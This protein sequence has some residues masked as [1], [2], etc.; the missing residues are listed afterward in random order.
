MSSFLT[1]IFAQ[2]L[3]ILQHFFENSNAIRC[4]C[5]EEHCV[6]Y[7]ECEANVCLVGL[8]SGKGKFILFN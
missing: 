1:L 2:I 7:G 3:I 4:F 5:T 6:P 8:T